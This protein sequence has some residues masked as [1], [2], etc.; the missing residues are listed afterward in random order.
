MLAERYDYP[1]LA[2]MLLPANE[3]KP[4]PTID[5]RDQWNELGEEVKTYWIEQAEKALD[6]EWPALTAVRYMDF[7]RDGNRSRYE[8]L[9]FGRRRML[10]ILVIAECIE[11][12]GRF[13]DQ[14]VNGIWAICEETY[15]VIPAHLS[16]SSLNRYE[17]LPDAAD[18]YIDLFA[19]ETGSLLAYT[20]YLLRNKLDSISKNIVLR[21]EKELKIRVMDPF[22]VR[23]D[24]WWMGLTDNRKVNNWNPWTTSNCLQ[25]CLLIE[26]CNSLRLDAVYKTMRLIDRYID[27]M[28]NDGG[29]DEG[30]AYWVRAG[31]S[32]FN[33]LEMIYEV[34]GGQVSIYQDPK[35]KNIGRYIYR[36]YIANRQFINFAD[37]S[38]RFTVD[39]V[40]VHSIARRIQDHQMMNFA[41]PFYQVNIYEN[42]I[43][44]LP[45][46]LPHV[47]YGAEMTDV[48]GENLVQRDVWLPDTEF[49]A[50]RQTALANKGLFLAAKGGHNDESH[51]HN[52]V[53]QFIIYANAEPFL[54]D[55]GVEEYTAKTFS[56][57]RYDIWTM[58]SS[59][60]NLPSVNQIQQSY[61][62]TYKS[63]QVRYEAHEHQVELSMN[64]AGAYPD[65]AEII[66]WTRTLKLSRDEPAFIELTESFALKQATSDVILHF[67]TPWEPTIDSN[68][69]ITLKSH[70]GNGIILS[71]DASCVTATYER[72]ALDSRKLIKLWGEAVYRI[73]IKPKEAVQQSQWIFSVQEL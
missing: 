15:W 70:S 22:L 45:R 18:M 28:P 65:D 43:F 47:F 71:F 66:D 59:Y 67:M 54:I 26:Q 3:Y 72:I 10:G 27:S 1:K 13:L 50:A 61:G 60:H 56:A 21:I 6:Y 34:T 11:N 12:K 38:T 68:G 40:L 8:D 36:A 73:F 14:I 58:Q 7:K 39:A 69:T 5:D 2:S 9:Y 30:P 20:A 25:T 63:D 31:A 55:V 17:C 57:E 49:M 62:E 16:G 41:K 48:D 52:D 24:Y 32:L 35:I 23:E 33:C 64:L 29:C 53:G 19:A 4:F 42:E 51:N 44:S 46:V 37:G